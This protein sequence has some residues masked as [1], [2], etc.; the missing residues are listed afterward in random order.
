MMEPRWGS[1]DAEG[2][3]FQHTPIERELERTLKAFK[4]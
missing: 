3:A 4:H 2:I 1:D